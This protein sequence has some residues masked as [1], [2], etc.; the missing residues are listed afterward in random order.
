[1]NKILTSP[2][3]FQKEDKTPLII[4]GPCSAETEAQLLAT[5][6]ALKAIGNIDILRAGI[7][8]PRTRPGTFEGVGS[9]GLPWLREAKNVTGLPVA[10][11]VASATQVL[12]AMQHDVDVLWIGART[13]ANPFSVQEIANAL[14]GTDIP[15]L[16]KNP[17]NPDIGLWVGAVERLM[18]AGLHQIGL[19]HRGFSS[20]NAGQYRN[21]PMWQLAMQM[22]DR[23]PEKI[24]LNDPSHIAG[25]RI[26]LKGLMQTAIDLSFDGFIIESHIDPENAWSDADQQVTPEALRG[27]LDEVISKRNIQRKHTHLSE[28]LLRLQIRELNDEMAVINSKKESIVSQ[29]KSVIHMY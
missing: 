25:K 28:E 9:K 15:V 2:S 6:I 16:I 12:E 26:K 10:I 27:L 13:T 23:F 21:A 5:A 4:S 20:P 14:K 22:K 8:K 24:M 19:V 3:I 17:V 1:M 7:W 18:N 11:E 29:L